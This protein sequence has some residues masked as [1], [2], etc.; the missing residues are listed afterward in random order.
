MNSLT[1]APDPAL[2]PALAPASARPRR[3]L[4]PWLPGGLLLLSLL[5]AGSGLAWLTGAGDAFDDGLHIVVGNQD[6]PGDGAGSWLAVVAGLLAGGAALVAGVLT[7]LVVVLLVLLVVPLA[8]ALALL[9]VAL[10]LAAAVLSLLA[11]AAAGLL[12]LWLSLLLLWLLL[13]RKPAAA[14]AGSPAPNP[15]NPALG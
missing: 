1:L 15:P 10:G 12:P 11:V 9:G 4:W 8:L 14:T 5:A 2:A 6:W 7:V 3:S 13:R